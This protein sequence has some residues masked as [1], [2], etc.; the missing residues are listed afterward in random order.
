QRSLWQRIK[1]VALTDVA[2]IARGGVDAGSLEALEQ[3]LLESDFGV[4]VTVRLV[5]E[6]KRQATRGTVK[7]QDEFLRALEAGVT[8]ALSAGKSVP[9]RVLADAARTL[10]LVLGV[11]GAGKTTFMGKVAARLR[12]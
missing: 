3:L 4:P 9:S 11:N 7:S 10:I 12:A 6:V 2:V 1:D 8:A 5:E